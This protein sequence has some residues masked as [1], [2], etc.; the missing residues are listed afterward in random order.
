MP[1]ITDIKQ[2]KRFQDRFSVFV[3][4]QYAFSIGDLDLSAASLSVGQELSEDEMHHWQERGGQ[5]KALDL[6]MR[7]VSI[8]GRSRREI[9]DY[10]GKKGCAGE[11]AEAAL[12]RLEKLGLVDDAAFA[13]S[14]VQGR[15]RLRPRSRR[16]LEQELA[17]KGV[18]KEIVSSV[19]AVSA[20][21]ASELA[22]VAAVIDKKLKLPQYRNPEKLTAYLMRQGYPYDT[23]KQALESREP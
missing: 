22:S 19:M 8:R 9:L 18:S 20:D 11:P 13:L 7:F 10:L 3:D 4:G 5:R 15:Q 6:A 12:G 21:K 1:T 17:T 14:W 2:L 16:V 23:I